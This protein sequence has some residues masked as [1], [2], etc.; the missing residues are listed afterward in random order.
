[1]NKLHLG[2]GH[3][4]LE[5]WVNTDSCPV[6]SDVLSLDVS[7]PFPL[8]DNQFDCVFSEHMIEHLSYVEGLSV[9]KESYRVLKKGGIIRVSTPDIEFLI[10]LYNGHKTELQKRYIKWATDTFISNA[11]SYSD[12]YVINNF[13]RDWGHLFIYDKKILCDSLERAGFKSIR[14]CLLNE[15]SHE[16]LRNLENVTRM[17]AGFLALETFTLEAEK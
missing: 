2:C 15:S 1:M 16:A 7:K 17:P 8:D 14:R 5:G 3:N 6:S 11:P 13:V 10:N 4:I 12:T 9:L